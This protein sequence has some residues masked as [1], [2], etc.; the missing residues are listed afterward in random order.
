MQLRGENDRLQTEIAVSSSYV[1]GPERHH[2]F[3]TVEEANYNQFKFSSDKNRIDQFN[4]RIN[5]L[6][7]EFIESIP[8]QSIET[9]PYDTGMSTVYSVNVTSDFA[10]VQHIQQKIASLEYD[11]E[12]T[13]LVNRQ[14]MNSNTDKLRRLSKELGYSLQQARPYYDALKRSKAARLT[15]E[16]LSMQYRRTV[17]VLKGARELVQVNSPK[18]IEKTENVVFIGFLTKSRKNFRN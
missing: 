5:E 2:S 11:A 10:R 4:D 17:H 8:D 9:D 6:N 14:L 12:Q 18:K 1:S 7:Q 16:K 3:D 15:T 13:R